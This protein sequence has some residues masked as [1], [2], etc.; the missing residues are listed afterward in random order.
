MKFIKEEIFILQTEWQRWEVWN[1][2][3]TTLTES[4]FSRRTNNT[5]L[6]HLDHLDHLD[7]S[8]YVLLLL[9]TSRGVIDGINVSTGLSC[10]RVDDSGHDATPMVPWG[11]GGPLPTGQN[12]PWRQRS[13]RGRVAGQISKRRKE[14]GRLAVYRTEIQRARRRAFYLV[15][16]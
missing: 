16:C 1:E 14:L 7:L 6:D 5:S 3:T 13:V 10:G 9:Q 8:L 2:V 15:G 4:P 11:R 12:P